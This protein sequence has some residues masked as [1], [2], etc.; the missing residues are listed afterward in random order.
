MKMKK[1][2]LLSLALAGAMLTGCGSE[3]SEQGSTPDGGSSGGQ[4]SS[5][6]SSAESSSGSE[7]TPESSEETQQGGQSSGEVV[8]IKWI[9]MGNGMPE[10]YDAWKANLDKYLE[11]KIGVHLDVEIVK[12]DDWGNR[13]SVIINTNEA[14]DILFTDGGSYVSDVR[15][16]AFADITTLLDSTPGLKSLIP[17]AYWEAVSVDGKVY[18][19]PAYKDSSVTNY[20]IWDKALAEKYEIDYTNM[21]DLQS[22]TEALTTLKE[23][24]NGTPFVLT[25]DGLGPVLSNYDGLGVGLPGIGVAYDDPS[26]TAV[27]IYEQEDVMENLRTLHD[28][29]KKGII[30]NDANTLLEAPK[31]RMCYVAQGWSLAAKTVWGP[32]MGVEVEAV[33]WGDTHLARDTVSGSMSCISSSSK[34]PEKA[35]Q[36]L[37]LVNTDSYVRDAL[38]FGLE[39]DDFDYTEDNRVHRNKTDW[40]MPGYAQGTFFNVTLTDDVEV[41]QWDEVRA[42]NEAAI[43]SPAL[44]VSIDT[45]A[46]ADELANCNEVIKRYKSDILTG[47]ADP[48]VEVPKMM[49]E[50]RSAGF[51]TILENVQSQLDASK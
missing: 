21:H 10:N 4:E 31:Y 27:A 47:V 45:T 17:E 18:A 1:W 11:E 13:R 42:L 20:F 50:L 5:A 37:E 40:P 51:D 26:L 25:S 14:Y 9:M 49:E 39:G 35:L 19:V 29:W 6:E 23:N 22:M 7:S 3:P 38:Y 36:L 33:Q 48:D 32:N 46:F 44:G 28:W 8:D 15:L 2:K 34:N 16:N 43:P 24:E 12:W 30:N 41:N